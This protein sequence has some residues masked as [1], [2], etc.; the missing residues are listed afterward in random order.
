M[1]I[2]AG[3]SDPS[4]E[5]PPNLI[6]DYS[7]NSGHWEDGN[8][9]EFEIKEKIIYSL[10]FGDPEDE[11]TYSS[12]FI[13]DSL[14]IDIKVR[15]AGHTNNYA[16]KYGW[17]LGSDTVHGRFLVNGKTVKNPTHLYKLK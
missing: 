16:Y 11:L 15:G 2:I 14:R 9:L 6:K 10:Y 4:D 13:G 8:G 7:L 5:V 3:C 12:R 17:E 1:L